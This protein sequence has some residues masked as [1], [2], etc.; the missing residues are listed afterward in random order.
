VESANAFAVDTQGRPTTAEGNIQ[1]MYRFHCAGA[2]SARIDKLGV[3]LSDQLPGL[4]K[5]KLQLA[6]DKGDM[7]KELSPASADVT[8]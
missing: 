7:T 2:P 8:F 3:R 4:E 1:A 6:S 5:V